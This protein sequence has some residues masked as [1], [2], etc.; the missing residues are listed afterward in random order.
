MII[1][2]SCR[3]HVGRYLRKHFVRGQF[4][5]FK[6]HI[7]T[8]I[9]YYFTSKY[10][11]KLLLLQLLKMLESRSQIDFTINPNSFSVYLSI[12]LNQSVYYIRLNAARAF[13]KDRKLLL[14]ISLTNI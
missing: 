8:T 3:C 2:I 1:T 7:N 6:L 14:S 11:H 5:I 9:V 10:K 4:N 12:P 13:C